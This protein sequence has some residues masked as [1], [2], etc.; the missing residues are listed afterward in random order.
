LAPPADGYG[1]ADVSVLFDV[2]V[3][4]DVEVEVDVLVSVLLSEP[5]PTSAKLNETAA[6]PAVA[7][8]V[9]LFIERVLLLLWRAVPSDQPN[10]IEQLS[11]I[12]SE[13]ECL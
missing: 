11:A 5:Q 7:T 8:A 3:A 2:D 6:R 13:F 9:I 10:S 12:H 4:V 1:L